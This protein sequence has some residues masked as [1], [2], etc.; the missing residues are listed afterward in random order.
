[1]M[2]FYILG[3]SI[4]GGVLGLFGALAMV[5]KLAGNKERLMHLV[6]FAAGAML[7]TAFFD[8]LPEAFELI[9]DTE[10]R[11]V[12]TYVL[13]GILVFYFIEQF[14]LVSHCHEGVCDVHK[15]KRSMII[16]GDT[17]HNFLDGITIAAAALVSAPLGL[18][19]A[20]AVFLHEIP[21]EIG[22]FGVLIGMGMPKKKAVFWNLMSAL[23][24]IVGALGTYWLVGIVG[25]MEVFLV[26]LA[27]GGFIYIATVDLLPEVAHLLHHEIKRMHI[28][29]HTITFFLGIIIIWALSA[30]LHV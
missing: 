1:M 23:A 13:G 14:L 28:L 12:L 30:L 17:V 11:R 29:S 18:V 9:G 26:A 10:P 22:D 19:T 15:A 27:G 25:S 8:L 4:I 5:T 3:L 6:S 24:T 20:I 2:L 21:Q 7:A 16:L